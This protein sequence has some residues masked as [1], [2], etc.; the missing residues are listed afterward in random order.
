LTRAI[1]PNRRLQSSDVCL[2]ERGTYSKEETKSGSKDLSP[3]AAW[4]TN[5]DNKV[6]VKMQV[7]TILRLDDGKRP[8]PGGC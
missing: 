7:H 2:Y 5:P 6:C 1:Q 3:G 4:V 8:A